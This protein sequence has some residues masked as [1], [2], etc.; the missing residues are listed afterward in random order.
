MAYEPVIPVEESPLSATSMA[1]LI[2][3]NG[4]GTAICTLA[5]LQDPLS[6]LAT[7]VMMVVM[8]AAGGIA[9]GLG[10]GLRRNIV[11]WMTGSDP[12]AEDDESP[13]AEEQ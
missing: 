12:G 1:K 4:A 8:G 6:F 9:S 3:T 2:A 5:G 13:V 11:R 10:E 7:P